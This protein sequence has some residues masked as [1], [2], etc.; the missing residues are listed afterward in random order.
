MFEDEDIFEKDVIPRIKRERLDIL[1][2]IHEYSKQVLTGEKIIE[3]DELSEKIVMAENRKKRLNEIIHIKK[4]FILRPKRPLF[5]LFH[6]LDYLP[7]GTRDAI[8][9][10]GDYIDLLAKA[11]LF[12]KIQ[13]QKYNHKSLGPVLHELKDGKYLSDNFIDLL[14]SYNDL[15][16]VPA[17]HHFDARKFGRRHRFTVREVVHCAFITYKFAEELKKNDY[18]T[19]VAKDE[20]DLDNFEFGRL[21]PLS[22]DD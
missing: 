16:Y 5:Y 15:F 18:V 2:A 10:M 8:R 6:H 4:L 21:E 19:K 14:I 22:K 9:Y 13:N 20:I 11:Y 7:T 12:D 3:A 1:P 17:K